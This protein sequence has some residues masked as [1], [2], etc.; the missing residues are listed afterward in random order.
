MGGRTNGG[1]VRQGRRYD[2]GGEIQGEGHSLRFPHGRLTNV[3]RPEKQKI[4]I[5]LH[6]KD[7]HSSF[8]NQR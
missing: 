4:C 2:A 3:L 8:V 5:N 6:E 1:E 7:G